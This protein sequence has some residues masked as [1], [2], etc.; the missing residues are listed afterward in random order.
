MQTY[1]ISAGKMTE[2]LVLLIEG[3][4][5]GTSCNIWSGFHNLL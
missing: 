4:C 3:L 2:C 5:K 1:G